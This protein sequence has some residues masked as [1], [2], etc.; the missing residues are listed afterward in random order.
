[1]AYV[2]R[3]KSPLPFAPECQRE[4]IADIT[5]EQALGVILIANSQV[6]GADTSLGNSSEEAIRSF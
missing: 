1:M 3:K 5:V 2:M 6:S 4:A